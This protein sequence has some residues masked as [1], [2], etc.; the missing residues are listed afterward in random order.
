MRSFACRGGRG[1][2]R[3]SIIFRLRDAMSAKRIS[4][5][6]ISPLRRLRHICLCLSVLSIPALIQRLL[7]S[8]Y[9]PY[10]L[11]RPKRALLLRIHHHP[12]LQPSL[13]PSLAGTA[14]PKM[15]SILHSAPTISSAWDYSSTLKS[16]L[17]L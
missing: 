14:L 11:P 15:A 9:Y 16:V 2:R 8:A 7:L 13:S 4:C 5:G 1:V 6:G 17:P 3:I 12:P 10:S